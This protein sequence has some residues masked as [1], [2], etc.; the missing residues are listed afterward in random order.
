[1]LCMLCIGICVCALEV[2]MYVLGTRPNQGRAIISYHPRSWPFLSTGCSARRQRSAQLTAPPGGARPPIRQTEAHRVR[3]LFFG[4][5]K[6]KKQKAKARKEGKKKQAGQQ[7]AGRQLCMCMY[8]L[9]LY[10]SSRQ[11]LNRA[12]NQGDTYMCT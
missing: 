6:S 10:S 11:G 12:V 4:S 9:S 3:V 1:M 2:G 7:A 5:S 8:V